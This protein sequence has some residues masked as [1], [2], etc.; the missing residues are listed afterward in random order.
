MTYS[1]V[2][3]HEQNG[4]AERGIPTEVNSARILV[5]HQDLLWLEHF[6]MGLWPFALS[7]AAYLWDILPNRI[8]GL[9]PAEIYT[10]TKMDNKT[11]RSKN[12]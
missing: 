5:L 4:V 10:G 8:N 6:D 3:A 9:T 11:L 7:R 1:G 12:T 2:G